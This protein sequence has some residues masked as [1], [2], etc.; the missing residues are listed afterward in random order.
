MSTEFRKFL[1]YKRPGSLGQVFSSDIS[2]S[3]ALFLGLLIL[4]FAILQISEQKT[5]AFDEQRLMK[6]KAHQ[7]ADL[8]VKTKGYPENW[9][10]SN[11]KIIGF[12]TE[13]NLI[14]KS[15]VLEFM[16]MSDANIKEVLNTEYDFELNISL[17]DEEFVK[18][19]FTTGK[20][21]AVIERIIL[22]E[23]EGTF[24]RGKLKLI[25]WK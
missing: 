25:L 3:L 7:I 19:N 5:F 9:N 24:K 8:M 18:G 6:N 2:I 15:K 1:S 4:Y 21:V 23:E 13:S 12:A 22:M 16:N 20:N 11:V 10:R 17:G 14:N